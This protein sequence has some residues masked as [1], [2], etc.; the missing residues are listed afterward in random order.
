MDIYYVEVN[1]NVKIKSFATFELAYEFAINL[2]K[3]DDTVKIYHEEYIDE[4]HGSET[5]CRLYLVYSST[6]IN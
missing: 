3:S 5:S 6:K 1:N 2:E 4:F